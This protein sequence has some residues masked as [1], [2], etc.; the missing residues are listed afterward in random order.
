MSGKSSAVRDRRE[1]DVG[2][3]RRPDFFLDFVFFRFS[4]TMLDLLPG[5][6][7]QSVADCF[8]V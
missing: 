2:V 3:L 5:L 6:T 1:D 7:L 4:E 8:L